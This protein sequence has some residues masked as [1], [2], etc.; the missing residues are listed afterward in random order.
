MQLR[1]FAPAKVNLSLR[2]IGRRAD[3][4]HLLDSRF[5]CVSLADVLEVRLREVDDGMRSGPVPVE[6][7]SFPEVVAAPSDNLVYRAAQAFALETG[8]RFL[9]SVRLDKRIPNGAG[10][11]GGSSDAA[12]VLKLL[13]SAFPG[14]VS[15]ARMNELAVGLGA[16]VPFF[17]VG[18]V[19]QVGGVGEVVR[20]IRDQTPSDL[21]LCFDGSSLATG[22]VFAAYDRALTSEAYPSMNHRPAVRD[23]GFACSAQYD[24]EWAAKLL[25]PGLSAMR[26][27]LLEMGATH[28]AMTGSGSSVFGVA[29]DERNA[30]RIAERMRRCGYWSRAVRV[31]R[32][33]S[34][35]FGRFRT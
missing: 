10:L 27:T 16:D 22:S 18:G 26:E 33:R 17:L 13:A 24:L 14:S 34:A 19:C 30:R 11:G 3:G 23:E 29:P 8:R 25:H 21:V 15:A 9:L 12:C 28:A 20:P 4:Y 35:Y 32:R 1:L 5:A 6:V 2:I 31:V 7:V